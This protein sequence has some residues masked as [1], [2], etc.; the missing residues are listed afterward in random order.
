MFDG[1]L[2]YNGVEIINGA[3][4][5]AYIREALPQVE[6]RCGFDTLPESLGHSAYTDP[7]TDGAPWYRGNRPA[8]AGFFGLF[9]G[10]FQ[11]ASDGTREV[12]TTELTTGGAV[13][14]APRARSKEIRVICTAFA[15]DE[16][17]MEEGLA[18]LR[19]SLAADGCS[20]I[21]FGCTGHEVQLFTA[22]PADAVAAYNLTRTFHNVEVT[23][24]PRVTAKYNSK[25]GAIW[26]VE[27]TLRAGVPWAFTSLADAGFL[28]LDDAANFTDP[29]GEDCSSA[30]SAY[31]DFID[32][33]FFTGISK[34]PRPPVILPPNLLTI[35]SW[36]RLTLPIPANQTQ[37][38]GRVVPVLDVSTGPAAQY[39]RLRF[40]REGVV[41]SCDYDGEFLISYI[42]A[43]AVL[44]LNGITREATVRLADGRVVP[45]GNLLF[46]SDGNPF[47][48][49]S[50]GCQRNYWL[51]ADL[52]PGQ[53]GV[54]LHLQTAVRE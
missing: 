30:S 47:V 9:P 3:R 37:R 41:H 20:E 46:G 18:W 2:T 19:D 43:N 32:D 35:H 38:W 10:E 21:D 27:F 4:A 12:D 17:A 40:Y 22:P 52:M 31:D 23:E 24:A 28:Y 34:P 36:R 50:L 14:S 6:I 42:P 48:W 39:L 51:A 16:E 45:A 25:A 33:P 15:A 44:T 5:A 13:H 54:A 29:A 53:A 1:Y 7:E 11:G 8:A 26:K 49:P